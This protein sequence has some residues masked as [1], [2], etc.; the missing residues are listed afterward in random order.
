MNNNIQPGDVYL[1]ERYRTT[2]SVGVVHEVSPDG[3]TFVGHETEYDR[4][5]HMYEGTVAGRLVPVNGVTWLRVSGRTV[6]AA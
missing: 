4:E 2:Y 3:S 6:L 5:T 1:D